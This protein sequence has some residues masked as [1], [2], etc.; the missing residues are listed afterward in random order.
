MSAWFVGYAESTNIRRRYILIG[1]LKALKLRDRW[2]LRHYTSY[3]FIIGL[4]GCLFG[5]TLGYGLA[6]VIISPGGFPISL[7]SVSMLLLECFTIWLSQ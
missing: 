1:T 6:V 3:G 4:F 2:I 5:V 7:F